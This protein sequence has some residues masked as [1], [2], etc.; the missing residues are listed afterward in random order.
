MTQTMLSSLSDRQNKK[1][2][3]ISKEHCMR[4]RQWTLISWYYINRL[5]CTYLWTPCGLRSCLK[6]ALAVIVSPWVTLHVVG[7]SLTLISWVYFTSLVST[8]Q[9]IPF[10]K[11]ACP[12]LPQLLC[13]PDLET[14]LL[15]LLVKRVNC[16]PLP[17]GSL[18][19]VISRTGRIGVLVG[20]AGRGW[21]GH[22]AGGAR[23]ESGQWQESMRWC[24]VLVHWHARVLNKQVLEW[25][26][27][28][29]YRTLWC[30]A[31]RWRHEPR[32]FERQAGEGRGRRRPRQGMVVHSISQ[33]PEWSRDCTDGKLQ[34]WQ[35]F[36]APR[37]LIIW[38]LDEHPVVITIDCPEPYVSSHCFIWQLWFMGVAPK[39]VACQAAEHGAL[40]FDSRP[41]RM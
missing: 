20:E 36:C 21:V 6:L 39:E 3:R 15:L 18:H 27:F 41:G 25:R 9:V 24:W 40:W 38:L 11:L 12:A 14:L 13:R 10:Q 2:R 5:Q 1:V 32:L 17:W 31:R 22:R 4:R 16:L 8:I 37:P 34:R 33:R 26:R 23:T 7:P 30:E 29:V 19:H 28:H 35:L